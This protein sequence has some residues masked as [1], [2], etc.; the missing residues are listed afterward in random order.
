MLTKAHDKMTHAEL[1]DLLTE[2][3]L[4]ILTF[5]YSFW[6]QHSYP[7]TLREV[8]ARF[9]IR[10]TN[11]VN[12]HLRALETKGFITREPLKSRS[13]VLTWAAFELLET[14]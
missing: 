9:R 8:G 14:G 13:I 7:A 5:L 12:N 10:S 4:A 2:R 1:T 6:S 3:Q 11:G